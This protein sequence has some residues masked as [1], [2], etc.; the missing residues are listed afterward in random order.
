MKIDIKNRNYEVVDG[1][2]VVKQ[3]TEQ[4]MNKDDLLQ[5]KIMIQR[6]KAQIVEQSKQ[7]KVR[8]DAFTQQEQEMD[9][10]IALLDN[11]ATPTEDPVILEDV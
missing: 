10:M 6:Q 9:T 3:E 7:L 2:V 4:S 1:K 11:Q 8:Y 5:N